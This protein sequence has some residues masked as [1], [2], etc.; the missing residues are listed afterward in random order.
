MNLFKVLN[1]SLCVLMKNSNRVT[2]SKV[3]KLEEKLDGLVTLLISTQDNVSKRDLPLSS[4]V[5]ASSSTPES[6]AQKSVLPSM[7][8]ERLGLGY[9]QGLHHIPRDQTAPSLYSNTEPSHCASLLPMF[10]LS[11]GPAI[12]QPSFAEDSMVEA[13]SFL[14]TFRNEMSPF[15][16]F[17]TLP[18]LITAQELRQQRPFLFLCIKAV[19]SRNTNQQLELGK[20]IMKQLAERMFVNGERNLDLLLGVLTYVGL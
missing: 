4:A 20:T 12:H 19:T 18:P 5:T 8:P 1:V 14:N 17:I 11:D 16:P 6:S 7:D 2:K 10:K 3:D 15:F 13:N 9:G